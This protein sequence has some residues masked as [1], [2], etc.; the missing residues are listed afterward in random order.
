MI[1]LCDTGIRRKG[2]SMITAADVNAAMT[3]VR[4]HK[5]DEGITA[6]NAVVAQRD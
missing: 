3:A 1:P 6:I 2:A 5:M 4:T